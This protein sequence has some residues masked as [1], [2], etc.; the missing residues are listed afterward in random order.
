MAYSIGAGAVWAV[1]GYI[2]VELFLFLFYARRLRNFSEAHDCVTVPDFFA[3]RFADQD[4]R[5]RTVLIAIILIFM[6]GYV[7]SQFVGG[8]KAFAASFG[9]SPTAGVL[10]TALI[11]L[12][13]TTLG[14]FLAVSLS[15]TLQACIMIVALVVVPLI[16]IADRGGL[17]AVVTELRGFDVTAIDPLALSAGVIIGFLG[18][19]LGSPGNPHIIVRYM[20]IADPDQLRASAIVA[21]VWNVVMAWG[22]LFIGLAGRVYFPD[23]AMLPDADT[24][25]LYPLLAAQH[26]HPVAFGI[27][28]ASIFAAI[29][30]TADSQLLVAAS[31]VVR[32]FYEKILHRGEIIPQ[33]RLVL[34]SRVVVALLVTASVVVG[35]LAE[36]LVFWLVLFAW[37]GLGA[38]FGPTSILALY[39]RK[40][41]RAGVIA[42][43]VTG[44]AITFIWE[45]TPALSTRLYELVPAFAGAL[46]ATLTVSRLTRPPDDVERMFEVMKG[47]GLVRS[48]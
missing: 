15:D 14:G 22:A 29:I 40:T 48:P 42:G 13:Y 30:S 38:S 43:L 25:K 3:A 20:S 41:T 45:L 19:G 36:A 32:D 16:A 37:A 47:R 44:T 18:I 2:T 10:L 24:E 6:V 35:L 1:T 33:A 28:V 5:L 17:L 27:V 23:V 12:V 11:V 9:L 31:S 4:G 7:S 39:W 21:T 8:G 26:L 34:Y 46:L